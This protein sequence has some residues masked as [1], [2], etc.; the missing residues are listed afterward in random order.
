MRLYH[1]GMCA[2]YVLCACLGRS[3]PCTFLSF[4][5]RQTDSGDSDSL[6]PPS[7]EE[8]EGSE[9]EREGQGAGS[10]ESGSSSSGEE[11][12]STESSEGEEKIVGGVVSGNIIVMILH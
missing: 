10:G 11:G 12:S 8:T 7:G 9:T 3:R 4:H 6:F 2:L 1:Y 5:L